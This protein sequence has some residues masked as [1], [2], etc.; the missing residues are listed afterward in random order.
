MGPSGGSATG[1]GNAGS[2]MNPQA[3]ESAVIGPGDKLAEGIN[4]L[5]GMTLMGRVANAINAAT[6][7]SSLADSGP[8]GPGAPPSKVPGRDPSMD[9]SDMGARGNAPSQPSVPQQLQPTLPLVAERQ[10]TPNEDKFLAALQ[11]GAG[12]QAAMQQTGY[13]MAQGGYLDGGMLPGDGMSDDVPANI[14]GEQPAALSSG[15]F[16][17]PADVVSH[18]GNGSSDAGAKELY[19]MMDRIREARTGRERQAPEVNPKKMMPK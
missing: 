19:S 13:G 14:D 12:N 10:P 3:I 9:N 5:V 17:V 11:Q 2:S 16:V 8:H 6:T 4:S 18:I 15:E 7:D 1:R